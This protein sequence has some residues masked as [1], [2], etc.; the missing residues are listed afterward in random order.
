M[1]NARDEEVARIT[2]Y[3]TFLQSENG[4]VI[5]GDLKRRYLHQPVMG[6]AAQNNE[7]GLA[8]VTGQKEVILAIMRWAEA[9]P[10]ESTQHLEDD[11]GG[12]EYREP[13]STIPGLYTGSGQQR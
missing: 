4:K 1:S 7:V 11:D 13:G 3:N 8:Y 6:V 12:A 5:L 10:V 2:A 9:D